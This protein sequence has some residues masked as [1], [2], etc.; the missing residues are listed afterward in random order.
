LDYTT[1]I[2]KLSTAPHLFHIS[3]AADVV[4]DFLIF[5]PVKEEKQVAPYGWAVI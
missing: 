5:S 4:F 2:D 3:S 1:S